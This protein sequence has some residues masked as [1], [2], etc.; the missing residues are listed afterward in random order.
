MPSL[1]HGPKNL[2]QLCRYWLNHPKR[3]LMGLHSYSGCE[4]D[5]DSGLEQDIQTMNILLCTEAP[6]TV[7]MVLDALERASSTDY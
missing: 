6:L 4:L 7:P 2:Q 5:A 3:H 1:Q